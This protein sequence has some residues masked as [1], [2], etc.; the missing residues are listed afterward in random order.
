MDKCAGL[1]SVI[2]QSPN[3]QIKVLTK[4]DIEKNLEKCNKLKEIDNKN[5]EDIFKILF[6]DSKV[7]VEEILNELKKYDYNKNFQNIYKY[8]LNILEEIN[9]NNS[10]DNGDFNY[11]YDLGKIFDEISKNEE[12]KNE[13]KIFLFLIIKDQKENIP[14]LNKGLEYI[15]QNIL[16]K[17][18]IEGKVPIPNIYIDTDIYYIL[19]LDDKFAVQ[20]EKY[21]S[22]YDIKSKELIQKMK[23]KSN[24]A[25]ILKKGDIL[26]KY[27]KNNYCLLIEPI[28]LKSS[29]FYFTYSCGNFLTCETYD[30]KI[31]MN[32]QYG[33]IA[34]YSKINNI[35][36]LI[37]YFERK[38]SYLY[39]YN[40]NIL[41]LAYDD[42]LYQ[43]SY[44]CYDFQLMKFKNK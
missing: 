41:F 6:P 14:N 26:A 40:E 12:L 13:F 33:R 8:F 35:Y 30:E 1:T 38:F 3:Y 36:T 22:F 21:L 5:I 31:M 15:N 29:K 32:N 34:V 28:S 17:N 44:K 7:N 2:E 43:Y 9:K 11:N 19:A 10:N 37:K 18:L 20:T 16:S 39:L 25:I 4:E 23:Y 42:I 27:E 24:N